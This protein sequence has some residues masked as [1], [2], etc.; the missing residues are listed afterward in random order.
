M[1][2]GHPADAEKQAHVA[3][4]GLELFPGHFHFAIQVDHY[5]QGGPFRLVLRRTA[6]AN[7]KHGNQAAQAQVAPPLAH[8][9][10]MA[11]KTEKWET[12]W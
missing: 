1:T 5:A 7:G 10:L 11:E 12:K 2:A 3:M 8:R 9:L 4:S 6:Q